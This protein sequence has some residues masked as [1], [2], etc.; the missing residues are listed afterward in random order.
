MV[1]QARSY[2]EQTGKIM[3]DVRHHTSS[4]ESLKRKTVLCEKELHS[5]KSALESATR[6]IED[7]GHK[8]ADAQQQLDKEK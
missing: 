2:I 5:T 4:L 3:D 7:R 6:K 1:V 8:L